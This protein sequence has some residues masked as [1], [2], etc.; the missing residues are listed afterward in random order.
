MQPLRLN[1]AGDGC[2]D[3]PEF[4]CDPFNYILQHPELFHEDMRRLAEFQLFLGGPGREIFGDLPESLDQN[5]QYAS[6]LRAKSA[7]SDELAKIILKADMGTMKTLAE[8][9]SFDEK[10]ALFEALAALPLDNR[11]MAA[12][13]ETV[14]ETIDWSSSGP[15]AR[16]DR[17][18]AKVIAK[19]EAANAAMREFDDAYS[20]LFL[21]VRKVA[22]LAQ[23]P[24]PKGKAD[25]E[26]MG[27][28]GE[29][30][31]A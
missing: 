20:T 9:S 26:M 23:H 14:Q 29:A 11:G 5:A 12:I 31:R 21:S 6:S 19:V 10:K 13:H 2:S 3:S 27:R 1:W 25:H 30:P 28:A 4:M 22:M 24:R 18:L 17:D 7:R 16:F 8:D 15:Q